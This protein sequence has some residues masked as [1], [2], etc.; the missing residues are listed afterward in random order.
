MA[1]IIFALTVCQA[2]MKAEIMATAHRI[3]DE[4]VRYET[5]TGRYT[6]PNGK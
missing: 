1:S 4:V 3:S 5:L 6:S 2:G